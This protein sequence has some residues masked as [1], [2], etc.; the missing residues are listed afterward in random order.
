MWIDKA[1]KYIKTLKSINNRT[2]KNKIPSKGSFDIEASGRK[3]LYKDNEL[4][5]SGGLREMFI[6]LYD[7]AEIYNGGLLIKEGR[8]IHR[9]E[10]QKLGN[11][12][13]DSSFRTALKTLRSKLEECKI[14]AEIF[15][16]IQSNYI[17]VIKHDIS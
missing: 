12:R 6:K 5:L 4:P 10:L 8:A 15:P 9:V 2:S 14:P 1:S 11:Y 17:L 7:N 16:K 3:L 13:S